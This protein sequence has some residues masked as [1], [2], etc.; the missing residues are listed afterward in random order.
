MNCGTFMHERLLYLQGRGSIVQ[1]GPLPVLQMVGR[2]TPHSIHSSTKKDKP[3]CL[4]PA[5]DT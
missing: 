3:P 2:E 1:D 5:R 4:H